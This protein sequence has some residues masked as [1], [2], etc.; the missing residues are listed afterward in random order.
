MPTTENQY[1]ML[2]VIQK[3]PLHG[4]GIRKAVAELTALSW[5]QNEKKLLGISTLY[6]SLD[7]MLNNG[8]IERS[9]DKQENGRLRRYWKITG[10]G[11]AAISEYENAG[12]RIGK[13]SNAIAQ[14]GGNNAT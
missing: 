11:E 10:V 9:E 14:L 1:L 4:Y 2:K 12:E 7:S 13:V 3:S 6:T 8:F 5:G